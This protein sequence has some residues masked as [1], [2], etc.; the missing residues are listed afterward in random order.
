MSTTKVAILAAINIADK[1]YR[2]RQKRHEALSMLDEK[3]GQIARLLEREISEA[4][5]R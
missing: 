5:G 3:T 1:L 2:E 4:P